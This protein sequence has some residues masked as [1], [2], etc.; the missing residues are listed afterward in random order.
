MGSRRSGGRPPHHRTHATAQPPARS[1]ASPAADESRNDA[2]ARLRQGSRNVAGV[3]W[4]LAASVHVLVMSRLGELSFATVTPE[5]LED[6]D[7]R[8]A[9]GDE[10]LVQAKEVGAGA[11]RL[12]ASAVG[13]AVLH[14][15]RTATGP[16]VLLTDGQLGSG[17]RFTGWEGGLGPE[18]SSLVDDL[19]RR[20][21]PSTDAVEMVRRVRLVQLPWNVREATEALVAEH[22][23]VHPAVASLTVGGLYD[24]LGDAAAEQRHRGADEA[25]TLTT[26]DVDT[27]LARVQSV[28]DVAG[29]DAAI[30]AGVCRPADFTTTGATTA[31]QFYLG[32][33]GNPG[34]ITQGLDVIR[35]SEMT[36][37]TEAAQ[38]ERYVVITGPSGSG[39]S[40]LL[41]RAARDAILGARTVRVARVATDDDVRLLVRHVE[42]LKPTPSSPVVIAA[43][44]LGR[45]RTAAW[46]DAVDALH[47]LPNVFLVGACREEDFSARLVRGAVRVVRPRLDAPT[48]QLIAERVETAGLPLKMTA[49]EAFRRS[50]GLLMEFLSLVREGK[51]LEQVLAAQ[52]TELMRPG[53]ELQRE[54]ARLVLAAHS[55]GLSLS[56]SALATALKDAGSAS[57][58]GDALGVLKDEHIVLADGSTWAG[59]HELR[60]RTLTALLHQSPPPTLGDTLRVVARLLSPDEAG[61]LLRRTAERFPTAAPDVAASVADHTVAPRVTA[62]QVAELLEGAERA[63]NATYAAEC[64]PI[65]R[66]SLRPGASLAMLSTWTYSIR[67]QGIRLDPVGSDRLDRAFSHLRQI[68]NS[69]PPRSSPT[70]ERATSR[71]S[72]AR[73]VELTTSASLGDAVR[74]LEAVAGTV[75]LTRDDA[76]TIFHAFEEPDGPETADLWSRLIEALVPSVG[77]ADWSSTF[78][79]LRHR[80]TAVAQC[81][82]SAIGLQFDAEG[83]PSL[84]IMHGPTSPTAPEAMPWDPTA[85]PSNSALND[86]VVALARQLASACPEIG[87]VEVITVTPS[88][89]RY[90]ISG[91]EPGHK[92]MARET[93]GG[94]LGLRRSVGFQGAVHRLTAASSWTALVT[95]QAAIARE[96]AALLMDA[97]FRL[98]SDERGSARDRW[99]GRVQEIIRRTGEITPR[100]ADPPGPRGASHAVEDQAQ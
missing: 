28:V 15:M 3:R 88:G 99:A 41:W 38:A 40:V 83:N 22:L 39:K 18:A 61:W 65:I 76:E 23:S 46:P 12:I 79:T 60:S 97:P 34:H 90:R 24:L 54:T 93:L 85:P 48:A 68:A 21:V 58:V 5:G 26:G 8:T 45:P 52:A 100:P 98:R 71:L 47:E 43:D 11:G 55:V 53:R 42:L 35:V 96:L 16:I 30:G 89:R 13:E 25:R 31:G 70:L 27:V 64:L 7:C 9:K 94:R 95:E 1:T 63:D 80:A 10:I 2:W 87:T 49:N 84:T 86:A 59:L 81:E 72:P 44:N 14:A 6:L 33:D 74:L 57:L 91:H 32:V 56:A 20:G 67:N 37:I 82:P 92:Q 19:I 4:Q 50:D 73:I 29:L 62:G 51:R 75:V 66:Q 77:P 78:G 36:E 69:L 17:L